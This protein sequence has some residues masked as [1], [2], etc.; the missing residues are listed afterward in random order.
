MDFSKI[1]R[2]ECLVFDLDGTLVDSMPYHYAAWVQTVS[3]FGIK[4][5]KEWMYAR[6]GVPSTKIAGTL[7]AEHNLPVKD[8]QELADI[9]TRNY[10][11]NIRNVR[12]FPAMHR[13]LDF[14]REHRIPM[15]IG[16][17][18]LR[19]NV[20]YIVEHTPLKDYM[21]VIVSA[22]DVVNHKP[23]PDTF[24]KVAEYFGADARKSAVFEDSL[25]GFQAAE[26]GGF[27][28]IKVVDGEPQL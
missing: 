12:I 18:T 17:G 23:H 13:L 7:I 14:A 9:K 10:L 25:F 1:Q 5:D 4:L 20:E 15:G 2:Y 11:Q 22:D 24:L 21:Q 26:K 3:P 27:D 19:S 16:T 28:L 6:G 8:P